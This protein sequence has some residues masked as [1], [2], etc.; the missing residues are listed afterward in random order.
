MEILCG[1]VGCAG[2]HVVGVAR[3]RDCKYVL[4]LG[5][6]LCL[7][8]QSQQFEAD[9]PP[10]DAVLDLVGV[11]TLRRSLRSLKKGGIVVSVL[12]AEPL[13]ESPDYRSAFFY[14]DITNVRRNTISRLLAQ[15]SCRSASARCCLWSKYAKHT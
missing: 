11:T 14:A 9:L 2:L 1:S 15:V 3:P 7:D 6:E 5:A 10:V 13:P 4:G 8:S 12:S